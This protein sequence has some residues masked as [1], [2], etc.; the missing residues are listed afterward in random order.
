MKSGGFPSFPSYH[1]VFKNRAQ[2]NVQWSSP[3]TTSRGPPAPRDARAVCSVV[4]GLQGRSFR[5]SLLL[6]LQLG[7]WQSPPPGVPRLV[8]LPC[9]RIYYRS[10]YFRVLSI[11]LYLN[12][13]CPQRGP[14]N[15][16]R[17]IVGKCCLQTRCAAVMQVGGLQGGKHMSEWLPHAPPQVWE[18]LASEACLHSPAAYWS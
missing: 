2:G 13:T 3:T 14:I 16:C 11:L 5:I 7:P 15:A 1:F 17:M 18:G 4:N 9:L 6:N 8:F 12:D 10:N